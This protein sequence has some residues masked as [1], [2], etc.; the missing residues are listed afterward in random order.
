[1]WNK[2]CLLSLHLSFASS[3]QMSY[4]S[5]CIDLINRHITHNSCQYCMQVGLLISP[6]VFHNSNC[7]SCMFS[8]YYFYPVVIITSHCTTH[9]GELHKILLNNVVI[10][11]IPVYCWN[12]LANRYAL[13]SLLNCTPHSADLVTAWGWAYLRVTCHAEMVTFDLTKETTICNL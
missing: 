12:Q 6:G 2:T 4:K 1:M 9:I 11:Q 3:S 10:Y 13:K 5:C 7:C 8:H